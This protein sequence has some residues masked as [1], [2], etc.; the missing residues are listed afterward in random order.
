[1]DQLSSF[2]RAI[3]QIVG[4]TFG[5][6]APLLAARQAA[7]HSTKRETFQYANH[8]RQA[9]DIYYAEDDIPSTQPKS[10]LL[11]M[12]GGGFVIGD[13][14]DPNYAGGTV[15]GNLAHYFA[16]TFGYTVVIPDYRLVSHGARFPSGGVDLLLAIEWIKTCLTEKKGYASI[17]LFLMGASAGG[18]HIA[19]YLLSPEFASSLAALTQASAQQGVKLR[20]V[21]FIQVPFHFEKAI[22]QRIPDLEAYYGGSD[23]LTPSPLGL[24]RSNNLD[25]ALTDSDVKFGVWSGDLDPEDEILEPIRDF[26]REWK[27]PALQPHTIQGHN[28]LSSQL[29]LGTGVEKEEAWGLEIGRFFQSSCP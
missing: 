7:I 2:G 17:N 9:L 11:Y 1:M 18:V 6:Y 5:T 13:K 25:S 10:V 15:Y 22:K 21:S 3:N 8:S 16:T 28:H 19:T 26:L 29:G 14:A 4:P 20:A 23:L 24:L 27:G 12:Y